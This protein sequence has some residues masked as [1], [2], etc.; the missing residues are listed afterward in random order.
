MESYAISLMFLVQG[1][2]YTITSLGSGQLLRH[3]S[4]QIYTIMLIT[5]VFTALACLMSGPMHPLTYQ[6]SIAIEV[7]RQ[8]IFGLGLG[9]QFVVTFTAGKQ[10]LVIAGIVMAESSAAYAALFQLG[11]NGGH[12]FLS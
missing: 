9:P 7:V 8:I 2:S 11:F 6:T 10:E 3:F 1:I 4:H 5:A 12:V